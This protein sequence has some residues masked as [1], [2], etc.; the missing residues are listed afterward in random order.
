MRAAF[1]AQGDQFG[2]FHPVSK[3]LLDERW[4]L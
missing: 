1:L 3:E 2:G 4:Q